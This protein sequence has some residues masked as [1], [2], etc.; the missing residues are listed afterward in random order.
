MFVNLAPDGSRFIFIGDDAAGNQVMSALDLATGQVTELLRLPYQEGVLSN[1]RFSPDQSNV[2]YLVQTGQPD[3]GLAYSIHLLSTQSGQ[4]RLLVEDNLTMT[5]P[6]WSPDGQAIAFVRSET[7]PSAP[8]Q[9]KRCRRRSTPMCGLSR[10]RTA[11]LTQVTF[12]DGF[13]RSPAWAKDNQTLAYVTGDGQ[14][15]LVNLAQPGKSWQA[16]GSRAA[17]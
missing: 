6:L 7:P 13:V 5:V 10:W 17:A 1:P 12:V 9:K 14:V 4:T 11:R 15:D 2:A 8:P 3:P 16:A